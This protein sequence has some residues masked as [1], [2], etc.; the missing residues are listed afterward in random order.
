MS[1]NPLVALQVWHASCQLVFVLSQ[2]QVNRVCFVRKLD[3]V[4]VV[5][6]NGRQS[7]RVARVAL[8]LAVFQVMIASAAS[9]YW[10][11]STDKFES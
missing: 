2:I 11:G 8:T 9:M 6:S 3:P 4:F 1:D 10:N 5:C 7:A